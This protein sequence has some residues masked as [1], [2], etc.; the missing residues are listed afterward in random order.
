MVSSKIAKP[1]LVQITFVGKR[2]RSHVFTRCFLSAS[3]VEFNFSPILCKLDT[4]PQLARFVS[5][6]AIAFKS[7]FSPYDQKSVA[8][9]FTVIL[10]HS[11][12]EYSFRT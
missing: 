11:V 9:L 5:I 2:P 1:R 7:F 4:L 6:N 10:R 3:V 12:V 8:R